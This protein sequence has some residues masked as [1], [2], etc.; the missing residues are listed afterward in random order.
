VTRWLRLISDLRYRLKVHSRQSSAGRLGVIGAFILVAAP[1][2]MGLIP[3]P[4]S[5]APTI[6]PSVH[7][8]VDQQSGS[9]GLG[10][11]SCAKPSWCLAVGDFSNGPATDSPLQV[12]IVDG[13]AQF[14]GNVGGD[15][16]PEAVACPS[17][18]SCIAVGVGR[19]QGGEVPVSELTDGTEWQEGVEAG[20][21]T[22]SYSSFDGISC[23]SINN[24]QAVG[25]DDNNLGG[26][27]ALVEH[28]NGAR[29]YQEELGHVLAGSTFSE[30]DSISCASS[31]FCAAVGGLRQST[32][33][34]SHL[35]AL[36]WNGRRWKVLQPPNPKI[37]TAPQLVN[38][39]CSSARSC[40]A[41][42]N[43]GV[44][45]FVERWNG[46]KWRLGPILQVPSKTVE[47]SA[48]AC[49][50]SQRCVIVGIEKDLRTTGLL[51]T[52][53][54]KGLAAQRLPL[55]PALLGITDAGADTCLL[56]GGVSYGIRGQ[57]AVVGRRSC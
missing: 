32:T 51:V 34:K 15:F 48:V 4:S 35:L 8:Q 43:V 18:G 27:V 56:V 36:M 30:L 23:S 47:F 33:A 19:T 16:Y 21:L 5:A 26:S 44:D 9:S 45:G 10:S 39:S 3:A 53:T 24:C 55:V 40:V 2:T 12:T 57:S 46:T 13:A 49:P 20:D 17:E 1:V 52:L 37:F 14:P 28:W 54:P 29:W 25:G 41:A 50:S 22:T 6:A 31:K 11:V 38:V 42:G 7:W